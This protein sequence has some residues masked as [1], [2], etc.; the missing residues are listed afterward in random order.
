MISNPVDIFINGYV[1]RPFVY[2]GGDKLYHFCPQDNGLSR[3]MECNVIFFA[4]NDAHAVDVLR[5]MFNFVIGCNN[6]YIGSKRTRT[7][8]RDVEYLDERDKQNAKLELW[9]AALN[10]GKIKLELAPTNQFYQVGW[11]DNDTI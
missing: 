8:F 11:A 4:N 10:D 7:G 3:N 9:L 1:S 6:E 5:R 2:E